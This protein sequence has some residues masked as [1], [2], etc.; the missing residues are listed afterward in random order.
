MDGRSILLAKIPCPVINDDNLH[1]EKRNYKFIL[2]SSSLK[3]VLLLGNNTISLY[4]LSKQSDFEHKGAYLIWEET[5][6][7]FER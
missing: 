1:G 2:F 5:C 3:H 4:C 6:T 7:D